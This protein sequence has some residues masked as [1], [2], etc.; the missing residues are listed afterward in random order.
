MGFVH[1][2]IGVSRDA[3]GLILIDGSIKGEVKVEINGRAY[4]LSI[5]GT[6]KSIAPTQRYCLFFYS[7]LLACFLI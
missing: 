6:L 1:E 5:R 2:L 7:H 4:T 3:F